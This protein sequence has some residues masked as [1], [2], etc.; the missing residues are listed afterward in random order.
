M[1]KEVITIADNE[2]PDHIDRNIH[3]NQKDNLRAATRSQNNAN[4]GKQKNNTSGYI[5][6]FPNGRYWKYLVYKDRK[7]Y[8][9]GMFHTPELAARARDRRAIE[10]FGEFA[11]LNFPRSDYESSSSSSSPQSSGGSSSSQNQPSGI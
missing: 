3:N 1:A 6:V 8:Y 10:L 5:G 2:E 7:L 9:K 4:R 11:S